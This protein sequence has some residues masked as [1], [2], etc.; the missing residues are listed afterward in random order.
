M[1]LTTN[2]ILSAIRRKI[3]EETTDLVTD[4]VA[5]LNANLAYD[6]LKFRTFTNDQIKK[7]TLSVASGLATLPTDF[8]TLYG[9]GYVSTTDQTAYTEKSLMEIDR[10]PDDYGIAVDEA[11]N[12]L[13][14]RPDSTTSIIVRYFPSYDALTTTQN[15]EIHPYLHEL[16]VYGAIWRIL[17]DLQNESLSEYYRQKYEE[18]FAKKTNS[19]SNYQ[20]D[21]M[22]GTMFNGITII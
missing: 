21:N 22:S 10:N 14:V 1:S 12:K 9:P 6:D 2:Q 18:E 7:T 4:E 8:G 19:L 3:L 16:I 20:E 11:N 17:E 5:L 13:I 15:P